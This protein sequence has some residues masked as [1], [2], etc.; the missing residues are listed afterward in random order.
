MGVNWLLANCKKRSKCGQRQLCVAGVSG[1]ECAISH[2]LCLTPQ[3][4]GALLR[5]RRLVASAAGAAFR[6]VFPRPDA[7]PSLHSLVH[8]VHTHMLRDPDNHFRVANQQLRESGR[9]C[10]GDL[11]ALSVALSRTPSFARLFQEAEDLA[12]TTAEVQRN[13]SEDPAAAGLLRWLRVEAAEGASGAFAL[14]PAFWPLRAHY[15]AALPYHAATVRVSAEP[16]HCAATAR[17]HHRA[18]PLQSANC[19]LGVGENRVTVVV[20]APGSP[21]AVYTLLLQR[22]PASFGEPPFHPARNYSVCALRQECEY[23]FSPGEPCGL[24]PEPPPWSALHRRALTL[25]ACA[26]GDAFGE[27]RPLL[28]SS[29]VAY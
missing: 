2:E 28:Q 22:R 3:D 6:P 9:H 21:P 5:W 10:T 14:E 7:S 19:T 27:F 15:N 4:V 29:A 1:V 17:I 18:G 23:Q 26:A 8:A 20:E 11:H 16:L 24:Q 13:C 12:D 25:P